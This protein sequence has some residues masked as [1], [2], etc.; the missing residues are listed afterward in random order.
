MYSNIFVFISVREA[1]IFS[2]SIVIE[3]DSFVTVLWFLFSFLSIS[4]FLPATSKS[5]KTEPLF[6][7][8]LKREEPL[9]PG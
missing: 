8:F 5:S 3:A 7:L 6:V 9:C 4:K 1:S 2:P